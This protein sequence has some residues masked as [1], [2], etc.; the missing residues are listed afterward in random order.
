MPFLAAQM[1]QKGSS[2]F[3]KASLELQEDVQEMHAVRKEVA[4]TSVNPSVISVK[5][6]GGDP[7]GLLRNFQDIMRKQRPE[8]VSH[9]LQDNLP[10][11]VSTFQYDRFFEKKIDEKK[12]T[13]PIEFL[14][15]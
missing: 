9:L 7:S 12:M 13:I 11:S 6:D 1:S 4:Q 14:K 10:K 8:R 2:V 5:A 3:R 15:L